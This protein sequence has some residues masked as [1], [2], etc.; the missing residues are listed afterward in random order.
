MFNLDVAAMFSEL[1]W[2][3]RTKTPLARF[4]PLA[5]ELR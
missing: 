2:I 3:P 5:I 4:T 1:V